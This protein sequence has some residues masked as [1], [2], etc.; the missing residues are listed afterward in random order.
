MKAIQPTLKRP[1]VRTASVFFGML[2][3]IMFLN[4]DCPSADNQ[5][6]KKFTLIAKSQS[7]NQLDVGEQ[8]HSHG[9][10]KFFEGS[11]KDE[12]NKNIVGR[13][14]A[15]YETVSMPQK[16]GNPKQVHEDRFRTIIFEF[17]D[18]STILVKGLTHFS[19]GKSRMDMNEPRDAAIIG[20]T[21]IYMGAKGQYTATRIAELLYEFKFEI[22][23]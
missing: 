16:S 14:T 21:G 11:F 18:G 17:D 2:T 13:Y 7:L 5:N 12:K 1:L 8:G 23:P 22:L 19:V 20:G 10:I 4:C 6:S 9:D 15:M 3:F